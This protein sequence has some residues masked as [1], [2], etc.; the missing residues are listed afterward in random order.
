[1]APAIS[2]TEETFGQYLDD[3]IESAD[4]AVRLLATQTGLDRPTGGDAGDYATVVNRTMRALALDD[5]TT[6]S[7]SEALRQLELVGERELWRFL[8]GR[9]A[10]WHNLT[11]GNIR[12]EREAVF[13]NI[14]EM[15]ANVEAEL[16]RL[17]LDPDGGA[18]SIASGTL[19]HLDDYY[20]IVDEDDREVSV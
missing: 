20:R 7:G 2:Y 8:Q 12:R 18:S 10:G 1:M 9:T 15:L 17:D 4:N 6:V 13:D 16:D 14:G 19:T 11:E 3:L 5:I